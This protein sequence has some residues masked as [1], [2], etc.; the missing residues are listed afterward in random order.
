M[1]EDHD[2]KYVNMYINYIYSTVSYVVKYAPC[3]FKYICVFAP[4]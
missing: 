3:F 1:Y 4:K 2:L